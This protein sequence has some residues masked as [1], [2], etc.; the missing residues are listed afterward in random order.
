MGT[1][2]TAITRA[3]ANI[4]GQNQY[5]YV[6]KDPQV[7]GIVNRM[8]GLINARLQLVESNMV[9]GL[10]DISIEEDTPEYTPTNDWLGVMTE[11]V[12]LDDDQKFLV[13]GSEA[14]KVYYDYQNQTQKPDR[15][16]L[17]SDGDIG[18]LWV[19]DDDY[20]AHVLY[21]KK[22][23]ELTSVSSDD[24]PWFGIWD[25]VVQDML[26][27]KLNKSQEKDITIDAIEA[28]DSYD[29]AIAQSIQRGVRERRTKSGFF[30]LEGT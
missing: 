14:D 22:V 25:Y 29:L 10:E 9:Y 24:I 5:I 6:Y 19:P 27:M 30:D 23:T 15:F 26:E 28:S 2:Q 8:L 1:L 7:L 16:Y 12:W 13:Q 18:F 21:W 17:N 11:G 3:L 4:R 20:T